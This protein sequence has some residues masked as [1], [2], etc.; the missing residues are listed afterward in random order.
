M[1][2]PKVLHHRPARAGG[3]C[4][5]KAVSGGATSGDGRWS[6]WV[7]T[8]SGGHQTAEE[9]LGTYPPPRPANR[10]VPTKRGPNGRWSLD[11]PFGTQL[12]ESLNAAPNELGPKKVR[13][14]RKCSLDKAFVGHAGGLSAKGA[15][16]L[17]RGRCVVRCCHPRRCISVRRGTR[18]GVRCP[19]TLAAFRGFCPVWNSWS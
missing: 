19:S 4:R 14:E 5:L 16:G 15:S 9:G 6:E 3:G 2:P 8:G 11:T 17:G 1:A 18:F 10:N 13:P 7:G 12:T